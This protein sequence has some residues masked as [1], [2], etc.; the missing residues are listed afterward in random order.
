MATI[1]EQL[2]VLADVSAMMESITE[3]AIMHAATK[4]T[5]LSEADETVGTIHNEACKRLYVAW[6]KFASMS[7]EFE[8]KAQASENGMEEEEYEAKSS[9]F[10]S[11][12]LLCKGLFYTQVEDDLNYHG[13]IALRPGWMAIKSEGPRRGPEAILSGLI[14]G[15]PH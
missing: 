7:K 3:A 11:L 5:P 12:S 14:V 8:A 6:H 2:T 15:G 13:Y 10:H 1:I 9:R 4:W